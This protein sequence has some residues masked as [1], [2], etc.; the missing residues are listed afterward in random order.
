MIRTLAPILLLLSVACSSSGGDEAGRPD[1]QTPAATD[2]GGGGTSESSTSSSSTTTTPET[3]ALEK[4]LVRDTLPGF[5]PSDDDRFVTGPLDLEAAAHAERDVEQERTGLETRGFEAGYAGAWT[6]P[7][8]DVV[9][10]TLYRF[11]K[12]GGAAAYLADGREN[13]LARTAQPFD[14]PEVPGAFGFTDVDESGDSPFTAHAVAF[15]VG[16]VHALVIV[17]SSGSG[18]TADEA[19]Q[20]AAAQAAALH[21]RSGG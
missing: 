17:G 3:I 9:L 10:V 15:S 18:R 5:T 1:R 11:G 16:D 6:N 7:S 8:G 13:L 4:L 20:V 14:V 21:P 12:P 19:R 2:E